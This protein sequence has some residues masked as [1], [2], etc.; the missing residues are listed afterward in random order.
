MEAEIADGLVSQA[1]TLTRPHRLRRR[2]LRLRTFTPYFFLTPAMLL[3]ALF[4][5]L[6]LG[7]AAWQSLFRI[8][9]DG[10]GLS[11][12]TQVF[13]GL[14]NYQKALTDPLLYQSLGRVLLYGVIEVPIM[15][16]L[17]LLFALILDG[18]AVRFRSFFRI[19]FFLPHVIPGI[20]SVLL[21][22]FLYDPRF[23]A[24]TQGLAALHLGSPD[25][26]NPGL[27]MWLIGN[28]AIWG[29]AGFQVLVLYSTL[30]AIPASLYEAARLDGCSEWQVAWFIKVPMILPSLVLTGVLS[31]IG[32]L[33]L[34]TE[35]MLLG[36]ILNGITSNFTP[37]LYLYN[38]TVS[39]GNYFYGAALSVVLALVTAV[40]SFSILRLVRRQA[41]V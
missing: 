14:A 7:Y 37:N 5:A 18:A 17:A 25:F 10:L 28:I 19:T 2:S 27:V 1:S 40:F 32:S 11:A 8:Q 15:L 35:P 26:H 30:Q 38:T 21:W 4:F 20:V 12:P 36:S 33:Q 6:P 24:I 31:I 3:F 34:F 16:G 29:G 13:A 23:S 9:R 22:G 41:G 39:G